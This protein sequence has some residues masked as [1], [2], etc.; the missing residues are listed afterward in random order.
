MKSLQAGSTVS[1]HASP[2]PTADEPSR[3]T[4]P[5]YIKMLVSFLQSAIEEKN[6]VRL[7]NLLDSM[8]K[9]ELRFDSPLL[10]NYAS[11]QSFMKTAVI[12]LLSTDK[13]VGDM[14]MLLALDLLERGCDWN[15]TDSQGNSVLTIIRQ[16]MT[17]PLRELIAE[18]HPTLRHLF[19]QN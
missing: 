5:C 19:V 4:Y 15:V 8:R 14:P 10:K 7:D 1:T 3:R 17:A 6:W 9:Q 11:V 12:D 18:E 16:R 2:A 13:N